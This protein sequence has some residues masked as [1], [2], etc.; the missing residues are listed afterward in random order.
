MS[1]LLAIRQKLNLTQEEL[2]EK[3]VV[4]VRTIQHIEAGTIPKGHTLKALAKGLGISKTDL[5]E[6]KEINTSDDGKWLKI[7]NISVLPFVLIPPL[8]IVV[9]LLI[10]FLKKQ[11]T[12]ITRM[13]ARLI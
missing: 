4:S 2:A 6:T 3:S 7:I 13:I 10:M 5:L 12:P 11:F 9:P 8:N 1:K